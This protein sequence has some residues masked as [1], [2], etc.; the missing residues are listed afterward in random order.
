VC[1]GVGECVSEKERVSVCMCVCKRD[2]GGRGGEER[3]GLGHTIL[4]LLTV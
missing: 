3:G 2:E 1:K 4:K